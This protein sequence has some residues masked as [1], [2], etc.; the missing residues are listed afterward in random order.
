MAR[1]GF[2]GLDPILTPEKLA[3]MVEAGEL[4]FVMLG[5]LSLVSRRMGADTAGRPI[6]GWVRA[7]GKP[8]DPALWRGSRR[9]LALYHLRPQLC[10]VKPPLTGRVSERSEPGGMRRGANPVA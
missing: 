2:H 6:A 9:G 7:N 3:R 1:G 4:R 5:D 8:A 10:V